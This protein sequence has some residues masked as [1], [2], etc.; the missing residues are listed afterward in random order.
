MCVCVCVW[1]GVGV[2]G[3]EPFRCGI[4]WFCCDIFVTYLYFRSTSI[5]VTMDLFFKG[6]WGWGGLFTCPYPLKVQ[7]RPPRDQTLA[8]QCML[9]S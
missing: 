6:G 3:C 2:C 9:V 7:A 4:I 1:V 5:S 8:T